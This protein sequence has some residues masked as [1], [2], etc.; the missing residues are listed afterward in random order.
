MNLKSLIQQ[1][2]P[3]NFIVKGQA[4]FCY[5]ELV[6]M[7]ALIGSKIPGPLLDGHGVTESPILPKY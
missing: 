5:R 6:A 3:K 7:F 1:L 2:T 4:A